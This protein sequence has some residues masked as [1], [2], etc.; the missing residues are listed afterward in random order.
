LVER[1]HG[2]QKDGAGKDAGTEQK[3]GGGDVGAVRVA[4]GNDLPEIMA[5][6]LVFDEFGELMRAFDEVDFIK[7]SGCD[8][9]KEAELS[10]FNNLTARAEQRR[11]GADQFPKRDEIVFVPAGA[12]EQQERRRGSGVED[13]VH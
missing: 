5:F 4:D 1:N 9:A 6:A 3:H 10:V 8:P 12:V 13:E 7:N 11:A 2:A